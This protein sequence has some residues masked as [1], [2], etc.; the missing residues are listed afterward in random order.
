MT[1]NE[2]SGNA[3]NNGKPANLGD[4]VPPSVSSV[5]ATSNDAR[6]SYIPHLPRTESEDDFG[7]AKEAERCHT[8]EEMLDPGFRII[9]IQSF[10]AM[11]GNVGQSVEGIDVQI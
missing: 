5:P 7:K 2:D 1:H 6:R 4:P 10:S 8:L 3:K 11:G 9:I